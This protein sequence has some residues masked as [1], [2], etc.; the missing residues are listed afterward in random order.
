MMV[1]ETESS[2]KG[3]PQVSQSYSRWKSW[4]LIGGLALFSLLLWLPAPEGMPPEAWKVCAVLALMVVWWATEAI[5]LAVTAL[6]PLIA[7][8]LLGVFDMKHA[9]APY[10]SPVIFLFM[11]GFMLAMAME[12]WH[13]HSRIALNIVRW[14]GTGADRI[15]G[16]FMLATALISMWTSNTATVALMM[17]VSLSI[18]RLLLRESRT[19]SDDKNAHQ[20]AAA[21]MLGLAYAASI[22]GVGTLIGTPTNAVFKGFME[23]LY[24]VEIG[25]AQWMYVG[26]PISLVMVFVTW[27]VLVKV[28][29]RS[30][31]GALKSS[32]DLISNELAKL[33]PMSVGEKRIGLIFLLVAGLWIF[34]APLSDM[35]PAADINDASIAVVGALL[36]F[37]TP[38][39][40]KKGTFVL[41][42]K[43]AEKLPWGVLLLFGGGL[44]LAGG[45]TYSHLDLW[46][47]NEFAGVVQLS[48]WQLVMLVTLLMV[49]ITEVMSNTAAATTFLPVVAAIAVGFGINPMLLMIPATIAAS[50]AFMMPVGTP[51]NAMVFGSGYIRM[52]QM[53]KAGLIINL[54]S[55]LVITGIT[56]TLVIEVFGIDPAVM[57][58][59]A[60]QSL[61]EYP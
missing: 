21:M 9:A 16:G 2:L 54:L 49:M 35:F 3:L 41:S 11:G 23:Q 18:V 52:S 40:L 58:D 24:G 42:W 39:D 45:I 47:G 34:N 22:G 8:P 1:E 32:S 57:P 5:S 50:Y 44:S 61:P 31:L 14:M 12:R 43:Q 51:P 29:F 28:L 10:A 19:E 26:V 20:F 17:P 7:F 56:Y 48:T 37:L 60:V 15:I 46:L 27:V 30:H 33:G 6:I 36:L 59:W 55:V 13:L 53:L 4:A 38:V 25:F